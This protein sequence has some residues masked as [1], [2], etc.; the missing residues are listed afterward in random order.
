MKK[1]IFIIIP[2]VFILIILVISY[3][4]SNTP[5]RT[6]EEINNE[7][8]NN[9]IKS[10]ENTFDYQ[11]RGTYD[12]LQDIPTTRFSYIF[13]D[14]KSVI[15]ASDGINY[16]TYRIENN[17]IFIDYY[18]TYLPT[19]DTPADFTKDAEQLVIIDENNIYNTSAERTFTKVN[20][21][22]Y[23]DFNT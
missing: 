8:I 3:S 4:L 2:T 21:K 22:T 5:K 14:D 23:L 12:F 11:I 6:G 18:E 20:D 1:L 19:Y 13:V 10:N 9:S 16:G 7:K 15:F 17:I